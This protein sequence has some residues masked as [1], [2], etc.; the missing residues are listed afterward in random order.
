MSLADR[1]HYLNERYYRGLERNK[2]MIYQDMIKYITDI[3][4]KVAMM[5]KV[6]IVVGYKD[7]FEDLQVPEKM[8]GELAN[9]L[10]T[11]G[12]VYFMKEKVTPA[13]SE[14]SVRFNW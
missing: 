6:S 14:N 9:I 11:D 13:W 8:R 1:L 4:E 12:D 3:M 5:G 2:E 7:M 10:Q